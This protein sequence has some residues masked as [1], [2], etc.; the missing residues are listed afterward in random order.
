MGLYHLPL[1]AWS[2]TFSDSSNFSPPA[3]P[4]DPSPRTPCSASLSRFD[5]CGCGAGLI[6][7][8]TSSFS[9]SLLSS[10]GSSHSSLAFRDAWCL[11]SQDHEDCSRKHTTPSLLQWDSLHLSPRLPLYLLP[12]FEAL[13]LILPVLVGVRF[14]F[15]IS[16]GKLEMLTIIFIQNCIGVDLLR[17]KSHCRSD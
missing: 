16:A 10:L 9:T 2:V 4:D 17:G 15:S 14:V 8:L 12:A 3:L 1:W 6:S 5:F 11:H 7:A 13:S